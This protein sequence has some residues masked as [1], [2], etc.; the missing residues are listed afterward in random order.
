MLAQSGT[1]A[2]VPLVPSLA[3]TWAPAVGHPLRVRRV[4]KNRDTLVISPEELVAQEI[5]LIICEAELK[6]VNGHEHEQHQAS[7][8]QTQLATH[9]SRRQLLISSPLQT[10]EDVQ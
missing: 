6:E 1:D 4:P 2:M 3:S 5:L 7:D 8:S 9:Q 10:R